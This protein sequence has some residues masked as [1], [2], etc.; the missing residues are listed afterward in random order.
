MSKLNVLFLYLTLFFLVTVPCNA[1]LYYCE[2]GTTYVNYATAY[3]NGHKI[4][5]V[6]PLVE[7]TLY[8]VYNYDEDVCCIAYSYNRGEDWVTSTFSATQWGNAH[9][10][11]L[12]VYGP[13]PFV[14]S[15]G[16]SDG[17]RDIFLKCPFDYCIPQRI[18]NTPGYSTL[19]AIAIDGSGNMHIVWQDDT[20]GNWDI[21]YCCAQYCSSV[22]DIINL[23]TNGNASDIYPSIGI[24]NGDEVH[25]VWERY[26]PS[27]YSPYSIVHR[28]LSDETWSE[29]DTLAGSTHIPLHHPSLDFS[30]GEDSLSAA[31]ED[32]SLGKSDVY[33][34]KGNGGN[35]PTQGES[36]H[37]VVSTMG[38][39]WSYAFWEDNSDGYNDIYCYHY[40]SMTGWCFYKF[41]DVIADEDMYYPSVANCYVVWTQGDSA[42]YKVMY[43]CDGYPVEVEK[44]HTINEKTPRLEVYPNPFTTQISVK[45]LGISEKQEIILT[46]YDVSG[47]VV[48][49]FPL[50]AN[51]MS[52]STD[53]KP[54]IYFLKADFC[55]PMKIVKLR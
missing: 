17:Q 18:S 1:Q 7:D 22:S 53:L 34:F 44:S 3:S 30:H 6:G 25:V 42:P 2:I 29:E 41:R 39:T 31:W 27:C 47:R 49:S 4:V 46:I 16:D 33:F 23:S 8:A 48:K 13:F 38:T 5:P 45:C 15:E 26:D 24:Y 10:P 36:K 11:S 9:Y 40:Y 19:S 52:V 21:Y 51:Y 14:V 54:G 20:P 12:D 28:Y 43:A 50:S 55:R 32:S 37:P 35:W